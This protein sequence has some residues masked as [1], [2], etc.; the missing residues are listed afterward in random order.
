MNVTVIGL[1]FVGL[2]T[3]LGLAEKGHH[4]YGVDIDIKRIQQIENGLLPFYEPGLDEALK[5]HFS[6]NFMVTMHA[7]NAVEKSDAVFFCVG[8]PDD[9]KGKADLQ[10]LYQ[11]I[12]DTIGICDDG[13]YRLFIVKSTV[14]PGTTR[15]EIVPYIRQ[16]G[17]TEQQV[18]IANNPEFLR[19]GHCWDDFLNA[20]RIVCGCEDEH[21]ASLM[22]ELYKS[23]HC[24]F[25]AV[26]LN[27]G[28]FIKYLS[29]TFLATMIS[30]ANEMALLGEQIGNIDI[31]QAFRIFHLDKR[32]QNGSMSSYAYPGCGYGG[33][34]LPKDTKALYQQGQTVGFEA[35]ILKH[36][37]TLNEQMP[38]KVVEKIEK[39]VK[40]EQTIGI[41]GLSFKPGSDDVRDTVA[42]KVIRILQDDGYHKILAFDPLA[43]DIFQK[44]YPQL[45]VDYKAHVQNVIQEA[46]LLV[47]LT[48]WDNFKEEEQYKGKAVLDC[49]YIL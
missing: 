40:Q 24:S 23:F 8:T 42:A 4:V 46:E 33:Y 6:K 18:G 36:V 19:E 41:L 49:R 7:A 12:D 43:N 17:Y 34:C 25:F 15:N 37:I 39:T 29:N 13:N 16:K 1:G 30:Y 27:T 10:Y 21:A 11:A 9:G 44:Q 14:P 20:D 22:K 48:G 45:K 35:E 38:R 2:T 31:G 47:I 26:S 5:K 32:W 3:A 28:E